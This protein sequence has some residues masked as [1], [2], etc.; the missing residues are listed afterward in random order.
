MIRAVRLGL[1][2]P[3]AA[4]IRQV[5]PHRRAEFVILVARRPVLVARRPGYGRAEAAPSGPR[6]PARQGTQPGWQIAAR[7]RRAAHP[8]RRN[9]PSRVVPRRRPGRGSALR[10]GHRRGDQPPRRPGRADR[11]SAP[12]SGHRRGD[13]PRRRPRPRPRPGCAGRTARVCGRGPRRPTPE[14]PQTRGP[15]GPGRASGHRCAAAP[16]RGPVAG[17]PHAGQHPTGQH[18]LG[19]HRPCQHRPC[20]QRPCQQRPGRRRAGRS[21]P[22]CRGRVRLGPAR[23]CRE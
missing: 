11:G 3:A 16:R 1:G 9:G 13:R 19:Q 7:R 6:Q 20:Q 15:G 21:G 14:T 23:V 17:R 8:A 2:R 12:G 10:P 18:Y 4:A 5:S 22:A